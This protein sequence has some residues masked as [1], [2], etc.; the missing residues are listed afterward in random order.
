MKK[1]TRCLPFILLSF[2]ILSLSS[3]KDDD[4]PSNQGKLS[5]VMHNSAGVIY[6]SYFDKVPPGEVVKTKTLF[7]FSGKWEYRA[8]SISPNGEYGALAMY[9]KEGVS[10]TWEGKIIVYN[11]VT[12]EVNREY[13]KA[14][15]VSLMNFPVADASM[16]IVNLDWMDGNQ[17][18]VHL[19][20]QTPWVES[21]PQNASL[22]INVETEAAVDL[23]YSS[24]SEPFAIIAPEHRSKT[25]YATEIKDGLLQVQGSALKNLI[26]LVDYDIYFSQ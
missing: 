10:R 18:L 12:G 21:V 24:R 23:K 1:M 9:S 15:L 8:L 13:G 11:V 2:F 5:I 25:K 22:I 14:D 26:T 19:Q 3:C 16:F 4:E 7:T 20:P 6:F 17:L